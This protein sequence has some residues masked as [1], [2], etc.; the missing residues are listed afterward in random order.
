MAI[1]LSVRWNPLPSS[2]FTILDGSAHGYGGEGLLLVDGG[3][4]SMEAEQE[5]HGS[6]QGQKLQVSYLPPVSPVITAG[7]RQPPCDAA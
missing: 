1:S 3:V 2:Q 6:A 4:C 7:H 5:E